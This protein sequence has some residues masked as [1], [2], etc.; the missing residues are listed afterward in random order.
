MGEAFSG[1]Q[2]SFCHML[3][4]LLLNSVKHTGHWLAQSDKDGE[5]LISWKSSI[6]SYFRTSL[7]KKDKHQY[8][9]FIWKKILLLSTVN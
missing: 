2:N 5:A 1:A 6:Y 3:F 4:S 9:L 8:K 7:S